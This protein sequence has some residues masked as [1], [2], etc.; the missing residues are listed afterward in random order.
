MVK[1]SGPFANVML[2]GLAAD[3]ERSS[4]ISWG[5]NWMSKKDCSRT[6]HIELRGKGLL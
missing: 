1:I 3:R 2:F 4:S 5:Q 6:A